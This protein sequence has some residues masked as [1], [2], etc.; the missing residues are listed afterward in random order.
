[1]PNNEVCPVVECNTEFADCT[2][3]RKWLCDFPFKKAK[4]IFIEDSEKLIKRFESDE[5]VEHDFREEGYLAKTR[6]RDTDAPQILVAPDLIAD[7]ED[8]DV[9]DQI[10]ISALH[11]EGHLLGFKSEKKAEEWAYRMYRQRSKSF[12]PRLTRR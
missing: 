8:F 1:M 4:A 9:E 7:I 2:K 3:I 5:E 11:E 6:D 10:I 12:K